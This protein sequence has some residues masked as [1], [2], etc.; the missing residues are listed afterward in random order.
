MLVLTL[1]LNF[2]LFLPAT[3]ITFFVLIAR[4]TKYQLGMA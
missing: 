4:A 2:Y 3:Q 1:K